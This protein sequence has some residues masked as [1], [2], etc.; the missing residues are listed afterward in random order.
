[1]RLTCTTSCSARP[2]AATRDS[3]DHPHSAW[4][5]LPIVLFSWFPLSLA[6][7]GTLRRWWQAFKQS[8]ARIALPLLWVVLVI[9]FFC[10]PR[11][12]RDVYIMPA[13]PMLAL[14]S[15]PYLEELI[16]TRWL[17][18][19]AF[20]IA[21]GMGALLAFAGVAAFSG[22]A[23]ERLARRGLASAGHAEWGLV[24]AIGAAMLLAAAI[25]RVRHGVH[26]LLAGFAAM[27]LIWSF[28]RVSAA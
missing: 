17:R 6:Y 8:E 10:I 11:G 24:L 3:W 15:A 12:K 13:L 2:P 21:L 18:T 16:R 22:G 28:C 20:V 23:L 7:P 5:Y 4:Y 27:W 26:A 9:A 25:F 1:M 14:A 19:S